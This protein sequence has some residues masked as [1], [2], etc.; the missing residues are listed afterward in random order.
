MPPLNDHPQSAALAAAAWKDVSAK[1]YAYQAALLRGDETA[2]QAI[3][4][5]A[6]DM[7]DTCLDLNGSVVRSALAILGR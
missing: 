3:R 2:A 4:Q 1:L 7:L 6:H 5:E